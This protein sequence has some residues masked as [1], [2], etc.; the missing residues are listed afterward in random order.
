MALKVWR[1]G[2]GLRLAGI[3]FQTVGAVQLNERKPKFVNILMFVWAG[4]KLKGLRQQRQDERG[5]SHELE[6]LDCTSRIPDRC[7]RYRQRQMHFKQLAFVFSLSVSLYSFNLFLRSL[8]R[9]LVGASSPVNHKGS[10]Q[11]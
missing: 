10:Y 1:Q 8:G 2:N 3:E 9:W 4:L 6:M 5:K 7:A 11:G